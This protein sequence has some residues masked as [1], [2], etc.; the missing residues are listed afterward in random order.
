MLLAYKPSTHKRSP[1]IHMHTHPC[2]N[3]AHTHTYT[4]YTNH[5]M[6]E[7]V[8]VQL[9]LYL[10]TVCICVHLS[11]CVGID[12]MSCLFGGSFLRSNHCVGLFFVI[13]H[14]EFVST[15]CILVME[16]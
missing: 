9:C 8:C 11:M 15:G 3:T 2:T 1:Y 12:L 6:Y 5:R 10:C 16:V 14:R 4:L 7:Y 13:G